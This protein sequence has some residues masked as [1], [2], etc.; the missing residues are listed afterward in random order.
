M[1]EMDEMDEMDGSPGATYPP[2]RRRRPGAGSAR[3]S[4]L[5]LGLSGMPRRTYEVGGTFKGGA[6]SRGAAESLHNLA[7]LERDLGNPEAAR[8]L[9]EEALLIQ[10]EAYPQGHQD[11]ARGLNNFASFLSATGPPDEVEAVARE[12][13]ARGLRDAA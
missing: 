1:D 3:R 2:S 6:P 11:L 12:S 13:L 9:M 5:P 8:R 4:S 10:R 7:S